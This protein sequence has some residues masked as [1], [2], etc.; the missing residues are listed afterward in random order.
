MAFVDLCLQV[1]GC[2]GQVGAG[3]DAQDFARV[4]GYITNGSL[5]SGM[6]LGDKVALI[7]DASDRAGATILAGSDDMTAQA[8]LFAAAQEPL[9]GEELYAAGAYLK[10]GPIHIASLRAEDVLRWTFILA[11]LVAAILKFLQVL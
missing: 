9:I 2:F 10:S 7:T 3:V 4:F 8:V 1:T 11:I 6:G 5:S